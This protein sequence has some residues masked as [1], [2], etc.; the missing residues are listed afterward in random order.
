MLSTKWDEHARVVH[1]FF[2]PSKG[3]LKNELYKEPTDGRT[4]RGRG[5]LFWEHRGEEG[6]RYALCGISERE[7][8]DAVAQK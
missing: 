5:R 3:A 1:S 7:E 2:R 8:A 6:G 4:G